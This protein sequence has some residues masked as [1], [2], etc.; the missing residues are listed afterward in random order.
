MK[1]PPHV[2]WLGWMFVAAII[3]VSIVG[4][5]APT[6]SPARVSQAL[7]SAPAAIAGA[8][9]APTQPV[10][11]TNVGGAQ[12]TRVIEPTRVAAPTQAP[13]AAP[14]QGSSQ[15][16]VGTW[17]RLTP[18]DKAG[19]FFA[20]AEQIEFLKD[21]TFVLPRFMNQSGK[22]SFPENNRIKFEGASGVAVY[23][24]TLSGDT[25]VFQEGDQT[26]EYR[27][28]AVGT[29]SAVAVNPS[30]SQSLTG[31]WQRVTPEDQAGLFFAFAEQIEFL[32]DGTF[33]LPKF[34]NQGG[35]YSFPESG[36][37]KFDGKSGSAVYRYAISGDTLK[38]DE[39]GQAIE[40]KRMK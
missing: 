18:E 3:A 15:S 11:P 12:A 2:V 32:K 37:V 1:K 4:C 36:R 25:L 8:S 6:V 10:A 31:L 28:G 29:S 16:L 9:K 27:R 14:A 5:A 7:T 35:T 34:M 24:F 33:I 39:G 13:V 30:G 17:N 21:G 19:L 26:I 20:F 38:F 23:K 22:Y 40:Y